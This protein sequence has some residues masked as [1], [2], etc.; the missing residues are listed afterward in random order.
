MDKFLVENL[1]AYLAGQLGEHDRRQ[2]EECLERRPRDRESVERMANISGMFCSFDVPADAGIGPR[3]G[4]HQRVLGDIESKRSPQLWDILLQPLVL[5]RVAVVACGWLFVLFAAN[6]YQA[7]AHPSVDQ[8]A[9][10]VLA[11]P[12]ESADYCNVRLG[13]D[14]DLNRSSML[15]A[16]MESGGSRR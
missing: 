2:F 4:F 14:I 13:C 1:E 5:R 12:P 11:Q 6:S 9:Q 16:V 8:I 3:A 15:A 10:T 7:S